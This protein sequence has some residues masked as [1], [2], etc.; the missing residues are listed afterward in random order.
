MMPVFILVNN[1]YKVQWYSL[2][3]N[4]YILST[5]F[6]NIS[7][8]FNTREPF[9]SMQFLTSTRLAG[10]KINVYDIH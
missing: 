9:E 10:G 3:I 6:T 4:I 1:M 8:T 5:G 7:M 2:L